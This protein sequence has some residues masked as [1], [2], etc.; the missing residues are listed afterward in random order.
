MFTV[1]LMQKNNNSYNYSILHGFALKLD[2]KWVTW[3]SR[4]GS[5]AGFFRGKHRLYA[6]VI[7][8]IRPFNAGASA[9]EVVVFQLLQ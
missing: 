6:E 8:N 4:L 7:I 5:L 2:A 1:E 3:E 9:D